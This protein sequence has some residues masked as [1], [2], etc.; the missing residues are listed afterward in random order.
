MRE[1]QEDKVSALREIGSLPVQEACAVS[2][3]R[4]RELCKTLLRLDS[5][6]KEYLIM[7]G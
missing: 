4:R 7:S 2:E 1:V 6:I 5:T 3:T